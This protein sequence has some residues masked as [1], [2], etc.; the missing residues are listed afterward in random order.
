MLLLFAFA[1]F[2]PIERVEIPS[3]LRE[4]KTVGR[5][6]V[7][8]LHRRRCLACRFVIPQLEQ[9]AR[10]F[11]GVD[12]YEI[13]VESAEDRHFC[14]SLGITALPYIFVFSRRV[15]EGF[16]CAPAQTGRLVEVLNDL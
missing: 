1:R 12:Y 13:L 9:I 16:V 7:L 8:K 5:P 15:S 3:I 10:R 11:Q 2:L 4:A 14:E 6:V